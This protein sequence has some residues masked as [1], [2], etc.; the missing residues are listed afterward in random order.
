MGNSEN[1][2]LEFTQSEYE[3]L[4]ALLNANYKLMC[5][6]PKNMRTS[7]FYLFEN[8]IKSKF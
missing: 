7:Q 4:K 8:I 2:I 1:V 6:A 3:Y 5:K